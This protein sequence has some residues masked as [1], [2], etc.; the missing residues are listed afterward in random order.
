[1]S[2]EIAPVYG[3]EVLVDPIRV[4][5]A[6]SVGRSNEVRALRTVSREALALV[7]RR[8]DGP[9]AVEAPDA[10]GAPSAHDRVEHRVQ[11]PADELSPSDGK[12]VRVTELQNMR[13]IE[14][15]EATLARGIVGVLQ[16]VES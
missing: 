6:G 16:V 14:G 9:A 8:V 4:L 10:I 5:P 11:A 3:R 7:E 15:G 1:M 12:L 2:K 13:N